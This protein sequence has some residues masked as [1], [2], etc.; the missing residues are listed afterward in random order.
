MSCALWDDQDI[1]KLKQENS[2]KQT[3]VRGWQFGLTS[4][5]L[6]NGGRPL[7][8]PWFG[9]CNDQIFTNGTRAI[10]KDRNCM[11]NHAM[12]QGIDTKSSEQYTTALA[13]TV[14][15]SFEDRAH[16]VLKEQCRHL[17]R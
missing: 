3:E 4:V 17:T 15:K 10:C 5:R 14:H 13:R 12:V 9:L 6:G 8:K 1:V 11:Y 2:L 7:H 16:M